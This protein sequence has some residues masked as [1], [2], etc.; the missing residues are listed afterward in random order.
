MVGRCSRFVGFLLNNLRKK[1]FTLHKLLK[2]L[3]CLNMLLFL[4][5][6]LRHFVAWECLLFPS[7]ATLNLYIG[8]CVDIANV[9]FN[10][11]H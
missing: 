4:H 11:F 7:L 2:I 10:L 3:V 6:W 8:F 5:K 9:L 1:V